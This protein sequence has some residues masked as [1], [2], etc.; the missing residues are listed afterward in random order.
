M[1]F[2]RDPAAR[3]APRRTRFVHAML[4]VGTC[5]FSHAAL[6]GPPFVTDD[7]EPVER[8]H[9]EIDTAASGT[10]RQGS[11]AGLLPGVE[12]NYGLLDNLQV[13]VNAGMAFMHAS[14]DRTHYGFGDTELGAKYRFITEDDTGWRP[15]V[16][17]APSVTLPTGNDRLGL[18]DGHAHVLLP[19][20]MQK[21]IGDW[22]TFGGGGYVVNRHAGRNGY[23]TAGW[24]ALRKFG[25]RLQLGGEVFYTGAAS[26]DDPSA[27]GFNLGGIYGMTE[28]DR[29]LFSF[30]R[31]ITHVSDTNRFSYYVG[32][33]RDL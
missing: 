21:S 23:W 7:P 25:D 11:H 13:S 1:P 5:L 22:T 10:V 33:Q 20:W 18:G 9:F 31:G 29:I 16:A 14:G 24:A 26:V 27:V 32:Y 17:F 15:Q 3:R 12:V 4:A 2:T 30:G 28:H 6:A 19:L 8:G